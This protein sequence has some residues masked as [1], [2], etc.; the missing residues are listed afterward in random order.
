VSLALHRGAGVVLRAGRHGVRD[1]RAGCLW[2]LDRV[3]SSVV[4][5]TGVDLVARAACGWRRCQR[6]SRVSEVLDGRDNRPAV[7]GTAGA[8]S[9]KM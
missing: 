6:R 8:R 9:P 1:A 2:L 7:Q 4:A 3:C 5:A